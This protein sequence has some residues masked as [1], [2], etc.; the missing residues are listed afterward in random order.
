MNNY[1]DFGI[2][3][4][5]EDAKFQNWVYNRESDLFWQEFIEKNP[6]QRENIEEA[7]SILLSIRGNL[8]VVTP[9][10]VTA[11]VS[12][13]MESLADSGKSGSWRFMWKKDWFR[14]AAAILLIAGFGG[15]VLM[16]TLRNSGPYFSLIKSQVPDSLEEIVNDTDQPKLVSLSD[17]SSIMLQT[18]SRVSFPRKFNAEKREVYLL[19]EAFFDVH[20]NPGQPFYVYANELVTKVLGTSFSIRAYQEDQEVSVIVKTGKVSVFANN[21]TELI[22][23]SRSLNGMILMPN[24]EARLGRANL[25]IIRK[26]VDKPVMLNPPVENQNFSFKRTKVSDVFSALEIAYGVHIVFDEELT[27]NCT[28]TADLGEEPLF[29]KLNMICAVM[30]ASFESIDGQIII[31]AKGCK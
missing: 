23:N 28:I 4:L 2:K 6:E 17:G 5:L 27:E 19:G 22:E 15:I 30:E 8:D 3:A 26:V 10:E 7:K 21:A 12:E 18:N 14:V 9:Q 25:K 20:K 16:N 1:N 31:N 24:Q 29:E 11:R 13:I